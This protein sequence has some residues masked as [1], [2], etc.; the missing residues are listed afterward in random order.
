MT[1]N[2]KCTS[3]TRTSFD[4]HIRY[5]PKMHL[6][7]VGKTS[8]LVTTYYRC[9]SVESSA[10]ERRSLTMCPMEPIVVPKPTSS[11]PPVPSKNKLIS[12][13]QLKSK[14]KNHPSTHRHT[15]ISTVHRINLFP[16]KGTSQARVPTSSANSHR[17]F[18]LPNSHTHPRRCVPAV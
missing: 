16:R 1:I 3:R 5:Q 4:S 6:D 15:H 9:H 7:A 2:F 14:A 17:G 8:E 12:S 13:P 11:N 10:I 18:A